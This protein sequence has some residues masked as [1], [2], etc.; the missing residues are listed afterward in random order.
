M[1]SEKDSV[2]ESTDA[3]LPKVLARIWDNV[4][5]D[6]GALDDLWQMQQERQK[7]ANK[8]ASTKTKGITYPF[9][10][11]ALQYVKYM[12]KLCKETRSASMQSKHSYPSQIGQ[13]AVTS[14]TLW[15]HALRYPH[16]IYDA[17]DKDNQK[18]VDVSGTFL[19]EE[20]RDVPEA[21]NPATSSAQRYTFSA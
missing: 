7:E 11:G 4:K 21:R 14:D 18:E 15:R 5:N 8:D 6:L 1:V 17:T 2:S 12:R 3:E 19:T 13:V 20:A 10:L 16:E 9:Y